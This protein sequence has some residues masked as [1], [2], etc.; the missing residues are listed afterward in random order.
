VAVESDTTRD[1][2]V[3]RDTLFFKDFPYCTSVW[4]RAASSAFDCLFTT[5]R[6]ATSNVSYFSSGRSL[7]TM[8]RI[9]AWCDSAR[10]WRHSGE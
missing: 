5:V 7:R 6:T 9:C 1:T 4:R 2:V 10:F 3:E 8:S